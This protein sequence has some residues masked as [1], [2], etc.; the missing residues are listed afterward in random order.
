MLNGHM[1]NC[2]S[3]ICVWIQMNIRTLCLGIL[4]FEEATGYE[5]NKLVTD[6]RFSHFIEASYGS[7]Y[8]ALTRLTAEGL[9]TRREEAQAG[10]PAR[11][12]YSITPDGLAELKKNL[13]EPLAPDRFKSE[14][15]FFGL[16]AE[17]ADEQI[18]QQ[19]VDGQ[20]GLLRGKLAIMRDIFAQST[21]AGSR[22]A[23]GYGIAANQAALDF[24]LENSELLLDRAP[25]A[26]PSKTAGD[27]EARAGGGN[28]DNNGDNNNGDNQNIT[29][30]TISDDLEVKP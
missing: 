2:S 18:R 17:L 14:F 25:E 9:V 8:P 12:V 1:S 4:Q 26:R 3:Y 27:R 28:G 30:K 20:I 6:G 13:A 7:I 16:F 22:F 11:K 29:D 10:K 19:V 24:L 23:L 15:L 21:H 5:I